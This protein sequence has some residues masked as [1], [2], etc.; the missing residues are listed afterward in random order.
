HAHQ[1]AE[2]TRGFQCHVN[3]MLYNPIDEAD[4]RRPDDDRVQGFMDTLKER[5]VTVSLRQSR[6]LDRDAACGQLRRRAHH[7]AST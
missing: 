6:G 2:L 1:L 5:R 7:T 3:L 4:Y